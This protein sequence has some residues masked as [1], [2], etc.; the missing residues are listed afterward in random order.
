M[1]VIGN[2]IA[3]V[4]TV[5][6]K[7]QSVTF[8]DV[9]YQTTQSATGPND[10]TGAGGTNPQQIGTGSAVGN[11]KTAISTQGA[12]E[13][14]DDPYDL[15]I[16]G[17]AFFIVSNQGNTYFTRAGNFQLD[18][19]GAL[20]TS[21]GANVMGWQVDE[22][23]E[24]QRDLVSALHVTSSEF[25]Y[26]APAATAGITATGNVDA[27]DTETSSFTFN[28]YDSLGNNYQAI[29]NLQYDAD[30][31]SDT[32]AYYTLTGG[33][34]SQN[35]IPTTLEIAAQPD[36]FAFN[37]VT[38]ASVTDLMSSITLTISGSD[39][40]V[41]LS[42]I[43]SIALSGNAVA[44]AQST[45]LIMDAS[46]V[47]MY[48]D[49][50]DVQ[51]SRGYE[52]DGVTTGKGK[53]V[54]VMS[55]VGIDSYGRIIASYTNGDKNTLGQIAVATFSNPAGLEKVGD[56]LYASTMNSGLFDG[57]GEDISATDGSI[58]SGYLEM[59]NVDLSTEFTQM[60]TTQRGFQANSRIITVSD[61][62]LEELINLKR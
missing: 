54:G 6:Y 42:T 19:S 45:T 49:D 10:E 59:S 41:N 22:N 39:P 61:T 8:S 62:L 51:C 5:A 7:S 2:N 29:M 14:T 20:V 53:A 17:D 58:T 15:Q 30:T 48:S 28:F 57:I 16:S 13:R 31:S 23:G 35:G 27:S 43:G 33:L 4:N 46:G 34:I 21:T 44:N 55:S 1:D 25:T 38:G 26:T 24:V 60:I 36:S 50:T 9:Y 40:S 11:I 3:N 32:T 56:N 47:T 52:V 18:E 12:S 37:A